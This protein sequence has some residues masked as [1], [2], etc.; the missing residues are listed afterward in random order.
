MRRI[1]RWALGRQGDVF[2]KGCRDDANLSTPGGRN[3]AGA[4]KQDVPP[5]M[6]I[7]LATLSGVV[8]ANT[9]VAAAVTSGD[10][11]TSVAGHAIGT[12]T[13]QASVTSKPAIVAVAQASLHSSEA[14]VT[15]TRS[16]IGSDLTSGGGVVKT[17]GDISDPQGIVTGS[18]GNLWFTNQ[19]TNSIGRITPTGRVVDYTAASI[20]LSSVEYTNPDGI[21]SGPDKALWF[22]N[23][24]TNSIGRITTAGVVTNYTNSTIDGPEG[25]T[26]GPDGALWFTNIGNSLDRA[27]HHIRCSYQLHQLEHRLSRRDYLRSRQCVVVH[28]LRRLF[29]RTDYHGRRGYQFLRRELLFNGDH[30]RSGREPVVHQSGQRPGGQDDAD[31]D[32]HHVFDSPFRR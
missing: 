24:A 7:A 32:R 6:A 16:A 9:S 15:S 13:V 22:T 28:Q 1:S 30:G 27:D 23:Y 11:H 12:K 25:I 20:D 18:D 4:Q 17:Y 10:H 29:H 31:R 3:C 14:E 5:T 2:S 26:T 21:T 8:A 19:G